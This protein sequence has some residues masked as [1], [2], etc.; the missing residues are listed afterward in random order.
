MM[1][2]ENKKELTQLGLGLTRKMKIL[3]II[4]ALS[5]GGAETMCETLTYTLKEL[6]HNVIVVS[7]YNEETIITQRLEKAGV[8]VKYLNKQ[9]G[10]YV[11]WVDS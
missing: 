6:K 4:P 2:V 7:L 10:D 5:V 1:A 11:S 9:K 3:Q 8:T